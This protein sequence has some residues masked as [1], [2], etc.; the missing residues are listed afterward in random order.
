MRVPVQI[1]RMQY[2]DSNGRVVF[3]RGLIDWDH[4]AHQV[5]VVT[6]YVIVNYIRLDTDSSIPCAYCM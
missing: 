2:C 4:G 6:V 5:I 3:L 1:F